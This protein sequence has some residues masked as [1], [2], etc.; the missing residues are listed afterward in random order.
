MIKSCCKL[1]PVKPCYEVRAWKD[2]DWWLA[3][4]IAVSQGADT[5]PMKYVTQA[6]DSVDI[7]TMAADLIA[8]VLDVSP[9]TFDLHIS[10]D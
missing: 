4:V 6:K 2:D 7:P 1:N 5:R 3:E 9:E 8:T 10:Y